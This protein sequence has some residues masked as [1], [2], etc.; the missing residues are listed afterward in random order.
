M[1]HAQQGLGTF[2]SDAIVVTDEELKA[3]FNEL[4]D[5]VSRGGGNSFV[6][7]TKD[8][9]RKWVMVHPSVAGISNG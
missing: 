1:R 3:R 5:F 9:V 2:E 7:I 4:V 6:I 8:G